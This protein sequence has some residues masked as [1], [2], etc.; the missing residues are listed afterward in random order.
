MNYDKIEESCNNLKGFA[1]KMGSTI[2]NLKA[3]VN[4]L[5]GK[6]IGPAS[7]SF[8]EHTNEFISQFEGAKETLAMSV[9]FLHGCS[10]RY[11][12][13]DDA[14]YK[15][16]IAL[17]GGQDKIDNIDVSSLPSARLKESLS[18]Q[19]FDKRIGTPLDN[20]ESSAEEISKEKSTPAEE[21]SQKENYANSWQSPSGYE[22]G[23]QSGGSDWRYSEKGAGSYYPGS[24]TDGYYHGGKSGRHNHHDNRSKD[25][26]SYD[27]ESGFNYS[28]VD[29]Y[30]NV[31]SDEGSLDKAVL[32]AKYLTENGGFTPVQAAAIAG[33]YLNGNNYNHSRHTES[34]WNDF[35]DN[36][37]VGISSLTSEESKKEVLE[38]AGLP[39]NTSIED[40]TIQQ[41]CDMIIAESQNSDNAYYEALKSCDTIEEASVATAEMTSGV[42]ISDNWENYPNEKTVQRNLENAQKIYE[43]ISDE[44]GNE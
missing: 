39:E 35:D 28:E 5:S 14:A 4:G 38:A 10:D 21:T 23:Y 42:S 31:E 13:V 24:G 43:L 33:A 37:N 41:Q 27:K 40:L 30:L 1:E 8:I 26:F 22:S 7:E 36:D 6:W 12:D 2:D 17:V 20:T 29:K 44:G 32:I 19:G 15:E 9:L 16:L 25:S 18:H 34:R 11:Q 3:V